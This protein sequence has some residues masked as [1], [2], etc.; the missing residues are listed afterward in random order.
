MTSRLIIGLLFG[1]SGCTEERVPQD[2]F[3][4]FDWREATADQDPFP[5]RPENVQCPTSSRVIEIEEEEVFLEIDTL[6]CNY[7][8]LYQETKAEILAGD[9]V[10]FPWG[11]RE[12]V[13]PD[14]GQ[15][16]VAL[17]V[18]GIA[19]EDRSVDI[20]ALEMDTVVEVE[21][22]E[23]VE[24]GSPIWLHLHN[25]GAN[26]WLFYTAQIQPM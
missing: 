21:V 22:Q 15:G 19:I 25:H 13:S 23:D 1:L 10:V 26:Q 6:L 11:H 9:T 18:D 14:P 2:L 5:D 20:P 16:H 3:D 8:T 24:K 17:V 4:L 7:V 12:L